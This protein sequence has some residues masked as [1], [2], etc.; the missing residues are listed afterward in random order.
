MKILSRAGIVQQYPN[1]CWA[2]CARYVNN[3]YV[4]DC[5]ARGRI[6]WTDEELAQAMGLPTNAETDIDQVLNELKMKDA[7]D[8][9]Y[10]P[11][12]S[13]IVDEID[14]GR[15]L[16]VCI[17]PKRH[18][19]LC[20]EPMVGGH[21]VVIVGYGE[22]SLYVMDPANGIV[23][24]YKYDQHILKDGAYWCGTVYTNGKGATI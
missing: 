24:E 11:L 8:T 9:E 6:L 17:N 15:M 14:K 13:E 18:G 23:N 4:G 20:K 2:A 5:G 19:Y 21:Y 1:S 7:A 12:F 22:N 16:C 3:Y 10:I